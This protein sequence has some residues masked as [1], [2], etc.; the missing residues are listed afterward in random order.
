MVDALW[1]G[2]LRV[3]E[4]STGR[5]RWSE[6][7]GFVMRLAVSADRRCWAYD[8]QDHP[9]LVVVREWPFDEHAPIALEGTVSALALAVNRE[10]TKVAVY[11]A[12]ATPSTTGLAVYTRD[13]SGAWTASAR[14]DRLS[15]FDPAV[16][17][18]WTDDDQVVL[19]LDSALRIFDAAL[20]PLG[21]LKTP[22]ARDLSFAGGMLAV[23]DFDNGIAVPWRDVASRLT[24]VDG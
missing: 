24:S 12:A 17:M 15:A 16:T 5:L 2:D 7:G 21:L 9:G 1:R 20:T 10:G 18:V 4:I 3:H 19:A 13:D 22:P 14:T 8:R 11:G 23:G 6:G